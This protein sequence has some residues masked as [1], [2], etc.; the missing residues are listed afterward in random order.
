MRKEQAG[1]LDL[2]SRGGEPVNNQAIFYRWVFGLDEL[3]GHPV[4][5]VIR[6]A[7]AVATTATHATYTA[8]TASAT[9][10]PVLLREEKDNKKGCQGTS[11]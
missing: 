10:G 1:F 5:L 6:R 7:H 8:T 3:P 4:R 11:K 2:F 9:R